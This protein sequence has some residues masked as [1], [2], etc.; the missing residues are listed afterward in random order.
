[1]WIRD[2]RPDIYPKIA[3][4]GHSNTFMG[5]WLTGNFAIDPSSAS[6]TALY[7]TVQNDMTWNSEIAD[8]FAISLDRLP[9]V[10]PAFESAGRL[11]S[12]LAARVGLRKEPPVVIG[13]NDAVLAAYSLGIQEPGE[14]VN[15]NGTCEI[16][17]VC[18]PKCYPSRNYNIRCHVVPDRWLTLYVMNALGVAYEWFRSLFCSEMSAEHFYTAFLEGA[19]DQ[20]LDRDSGEINVP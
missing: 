20:W 9:Q 11:R 4:V 6:L 12:E 13:G 1:M 3:V 17:L 2:H 14:A 7:N 16:T 5:K 10:I 19:V 8:L 18:L 15:V